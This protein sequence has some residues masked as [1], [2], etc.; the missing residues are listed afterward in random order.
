MMAIFGSQ[1][2]IDMVRAIGT[3]ELIGL[4]GFLVPSG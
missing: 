1:H 2:L 3:S 4:S